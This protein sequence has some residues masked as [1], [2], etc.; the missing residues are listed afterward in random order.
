MTALSGVAAG[1]GP[2]L[3]VRL[4][5]ERHFDPPRGVEVERDGYRWAGL[6]RAWRLCDDDRGWMADVEYVMAHEW[7]PGNHLDRVPPE[8]LRL[9]SGD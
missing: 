9:P 4:L 3:V 5:E 2:R 1:H 6:Q 7:G 8:R